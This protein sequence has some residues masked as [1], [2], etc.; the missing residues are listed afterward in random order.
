MTKLPGGQVAGACGGEKPVSFV[1]GGNNVLPAFNA[2]ISEMS[3]GET[4]SLHLDSHSGYGAMGY[5]G[6]IPPNSD[7]QFDVNLISFQ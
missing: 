5:P 2:A 1:L 4:C 7:V 3:L 6:L